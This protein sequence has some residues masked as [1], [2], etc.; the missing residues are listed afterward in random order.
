MTR[1]LLM[2]A[3]AAA[4]TV[5]TVVAAQA[6]D[7]PTRKEAPPPV[8][9][10]PPFTWTGFYVGV[11]AGGIWSSGSRSATL[12]DPG[13]AWLSNYFPGGVGSG[14]S[15]FIG[16][17]QVGYNWQT[18]SFVLGAEADFDGSSL[19]KTYSYTSTPFGSVVNGVALPTTL[20]GDSLSVSAKSSLD[21][22]GTVRG[23]VGFVATPDNRLM[24]YG[25]GGFAYA[26]GSSNLNV[27]DATQG[28]YWNG[29]PSSSRSGWTIGGGV[30]YAWTNNITIRAEYLYVDLGNKTIT[31]TANPTAYAFFNAA[32]VATP[33]AT[34][35]INYDASI[36]RAAINYKF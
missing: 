22:I 25:T 4:M 34:A 17:G 36:V 9:V 7:L 8:Y 16:G 35:R 12:V 3:A 14:Q 27:Y 33:Y 2:G 32:G 13:V 11:N 29:N 20:V 31:T 21:W 5:A 15:G 24:I 6:A 10:P 19:S 23:R 28:F 30:E 1:R 26:G 18:G